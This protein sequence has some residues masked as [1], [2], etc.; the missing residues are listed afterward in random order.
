MRG[1]E[2]FELQL[3]G[4]SQFTNSVRHRSIFGGYLVMRLVLTPH[5]PT[6]RFAT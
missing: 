6:K 5:S 3:S 2:C 1:T 4:Y